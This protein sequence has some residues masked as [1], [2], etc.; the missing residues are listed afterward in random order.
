MRLGERT[1]NEQETAIIEAFKSHISYLQKEIDEHWDMLVKQ[2]NN[3]K[4]KHDDYLWDYVINDF[5]L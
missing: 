5:K 2:L 1:Y 3:G 4:K